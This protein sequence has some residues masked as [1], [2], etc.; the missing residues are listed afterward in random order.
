VGIVAVDLIPIFLEKLGGDMI[1]G[2]WLLLMVPVFV[3]GVVFGV[4]ME[5]A[6]NGL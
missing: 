4:R 5:R 6:V 2:W 3:S 1:S